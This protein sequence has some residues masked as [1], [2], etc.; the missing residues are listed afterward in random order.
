MCEEEQQP[1][2]HFQTLSAPL[3]NLYNSCLL[4]WVLTLSYASPPELISRS[5]WLWLRDHNLTLSGLRGLWCLNTYTRVIPDRPNPDAPF[6]TLALLSL[7]LTH[8]TVITWPRSN[9]SSGF[10]HIRCHHA[11]AYGIPDPPIPDSPMKE[12]N[13]PD[14]S[15]ALTAAIKSWNHISRF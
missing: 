12:I 6:H 10:R 11:H 14:L 8:M 9:L 5:T 3:D 13:G 15:L 7:D 4:N 1:S 2:D